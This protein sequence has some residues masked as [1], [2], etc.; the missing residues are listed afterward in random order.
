MPHQTLGDQGF[1]VHRGQRKFYRKAILNFLKGDLSNVACP[2]DA[3]LYGGNDPDWFAIRDFAEQLEGSR[4][5][6]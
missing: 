5:L 1:D 2:L 4:I 6:V 3:F